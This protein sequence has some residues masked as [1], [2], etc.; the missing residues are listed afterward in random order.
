[1]AIGRRYAKAQHDRQLRCYALGFFDGNAGILYIED[2]LDEQG[3]DTSVN[4]GLYLFGVGLTQYILIKWLATGGNRGCSACG[5]DAASDV[6]GLIRRGE[7]VGTLTGQTSGCEVDVA[8]VVLH[9]V[10]AHRDALSIEGIGFDDVSTC[11]E[12]FTMDVAN[13]EGRSQRQHVVTS[14]QFLRMVGKAGPSE[15]LFTQLIALN[16]RTHGTIKD[17]NLVLVNGEW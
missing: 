8:T 10:V 17:K 7:L 12:V 14:L 11:L 2:G 13:D 16:H 9:A 1:M 6:A 15:V 4:E 5:A 3:V